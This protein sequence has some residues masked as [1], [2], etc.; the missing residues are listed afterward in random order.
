MRYSVALTRYDLR[1]EAT[2]NINKWLLQPKANR[3]GAAIF[4]TSGDP[5]LTSSAGH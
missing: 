4:C 1:L 5:L 3:Q 2:G